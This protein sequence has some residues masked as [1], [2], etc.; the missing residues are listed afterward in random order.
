M[1]ELDRILQRWRIRKAA[2]HIPS[3][4]RVLDIGCFDGTLF[5]RLGGRIG[6]GVGIDPLAPPCGKDPDFLLIR[7]TFPDDMPEVEPFDVITALAVVEHLPAEDG[8]RFAES[9]AR[10]LVPKGLVVLTVP[11]PAVDSILHVMQRLRVLD[12][13]SVEEHHGFTPRSVEALFTARDFVL[14]HKETFQLGLNHVL[15]FRKAR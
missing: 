5:R 10:Y 9:C 1:K 6:A 2:K 4:A 11:A 3:G 14:H 7:G 13:M 12:G 8:P 15:V